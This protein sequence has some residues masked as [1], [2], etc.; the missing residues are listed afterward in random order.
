MPAAVLVVGGAPRVAVDAIRHLT[1][2]ATGATAVAIQ[3]GL[4]AKGHRAVDLLLS[5]D[6]VP[7]SAPATRFLDRAA[8]ERELRAWIARHPAGTI[9]LSAAINDYTVAGVEGGAHGALA[10]VVVA[11]GV[12][13]IPSRL[14]EVIIRLRPA[15]KVIDQLAGWG[16]R[17][18]LVG[19]K[20]EP[21]AT[22]LASAEQLRAR[23]G[24]ALVVANSIDGRV[25]ALV[26]AQGVEDCGGDR[27]RLVTRLVARLLRL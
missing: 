4:T 13:K 24:A 18:S 16:H 17:G 14:E 7:A 19:F 10:P 22:V 21:A 11:P 23:V 12:G 15:S 1:V 27:Q 2:H 25:Q 3:A 9:V 8:L 5:V 6:A 20:Y 26:D